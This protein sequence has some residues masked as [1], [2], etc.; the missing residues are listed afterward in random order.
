ML[1]RSRIIYPKRCRRHTVS[2]HVLPFPAARKFLGHDSTHT[3]SQL[4]K[5]SNDSSTRLPPTIYTTSTLGASRIFSSFSISFQRSAART[6]T[7]NQSLLS[8]TVL[9][10][11]SRSYAKSRKMP[12]KKAVKEEKILLGRP[13]NSLKSGI[14]CQFP[15]PLK[16]FTNYI[17][18]W[19]CQR[20]EVDTLPS[21]HQMLPRKS[22][23]E[24]LCSS[25]VW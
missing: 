9:F 18:G 14:V 6:A 2:S 16:I 15:V 5:S 22:C 23:R 20:R 13:G 12:P 21:H 8:C 1:I 7:L 19:S 4:R 3:K 17:Q 11:T 25:S 24:S 10:T